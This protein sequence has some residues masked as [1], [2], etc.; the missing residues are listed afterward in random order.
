MA[1][2]KSYKKI[3]RNIMTDSWKLTYLNGKLSVSV[4]DT[5]LQ[6]VEN[7]QFSVYPGID[8]MGDGTL[9]IT[10]GVSDIEL[11][12]D[13]S[14]SALLTADES[15]VSRVEM[16]E[17]GYER[18]QSILEEQNQNLRQQVAGLRDQ[19][20]ES[21]ELMQLANTALEDGDRAYQE[22]VAEVLMLREQMELNNV[23]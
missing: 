5:P 15:A 17:Q 16:V 10:V 7:A 22:K 2:F 14:V 3:G 18:L 21:K 4:N 8:G 13:T 11:V 20:A 9:Q 19:L 1:S 6:H 12:S 23:D